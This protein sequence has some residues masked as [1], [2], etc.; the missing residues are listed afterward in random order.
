MAA[1]FV[2][3]DG[4]RTDLPTA[5]R[6]ADAVLMCNPLTDTSVPPANDT[7]FGAT[8]DTFTS[9]VYSTV[10]LQHSASTTKHTHSG[11]WHNSAHS[12]Q[13]AAPSTH[14]ALGNT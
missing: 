13:S 3:E 6:N 11:H 12:G 9:D 8:I 10:K 4:S 7:M 14:A 1:E 2:H 5:Q